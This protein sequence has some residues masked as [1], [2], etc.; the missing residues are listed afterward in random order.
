[1]T[2][3]AS[4]KTHALPLAFF[5]TLMLAAPD[6][7]A[8]AED[9]PPLDPATRTIASLTCRDM[10]RMEG[11]ERRLTLVFFHGWMLGLRDAQEVDGDGLAIATDRVIEACIDAPDRSL[12]ETF[13]EATADDAPAAQ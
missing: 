1:M 2:T 4:M 5:A 12:R 3:G 6:R 11:E 7:A 13:E 9:A 10:L 8:L